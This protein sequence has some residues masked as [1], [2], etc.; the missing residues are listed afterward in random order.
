MKLIYF[1]GKSCGFMMAHVTAVS[2][3]SE[4]KSLCHPASVD[5][6][7][8]SANK[9]DHVSMGGI[10]FPMFHYIYYSIL[11]LFYLLGYAVRKALKVI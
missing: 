2:L 7:P 6:I 4:N 3:V 5:T 9:E 8:T 11:I 1:I 10:L